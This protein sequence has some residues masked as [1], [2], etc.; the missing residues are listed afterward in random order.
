LTGEWYLKAMKKSSEMQKTAGHICRID[1]K[2]SGSGEASS[3]YDL[4]FQVEYFVSNTRY[5][6]M[7]GSQDLVGSGCSPKKA[8]ALVKKF[9]LGR[10]I[11]ILHN[12]ANPR[13]AVIP[14]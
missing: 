3:I 11:D 5:T 13:E 6:R 14:S 8:E 4:D 10:R 1:L 2:S 9:H 7:L 12:P